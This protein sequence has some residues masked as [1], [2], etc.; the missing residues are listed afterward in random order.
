MSY[1]T[2][3]PII[4]RWANNH[5]LTLYTKYQDSEVR[6]IT[7]VAVSGRK[8][9]IWIDQPSGGSV[10][11][12]VWDYKKRRKDWKINANA[13]DVTLEKALQTGKGWIQ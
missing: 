7:M 5:D 10:G 3:D 4:E 9:Q 6:S 11:V 8:F 12:H 13:L 2:I 1:A